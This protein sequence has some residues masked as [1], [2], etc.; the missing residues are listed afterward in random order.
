MPAIATAATK[1]ATRFFCIADLPWVYA[2]VPH[3]TGGAV[4]GGISS[5][6]VTHGASAL[7]RRGVVTSVRGYL[8]PTESIVKTSSTRS[9][10]SAGLAYEW[11]AQGR[12][13][14]A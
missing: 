12:T 13:V 6:G 8:W 9:A 7:T 11:C 2:L 3:S 14:A 4:S 5:V 10:N 1:I